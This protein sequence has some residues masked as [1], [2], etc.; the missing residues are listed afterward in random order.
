VL[1]DAA[2]A[3]R[4]AGDQQQA[5]HLVDEALALTSAADSVHGQPVR[6]A[7]LLAQRGRLLLNLRRDG[8]V[9]ALE[10]AER[11]V[12]A[13]PA[14][15]RVTVLDVLAAALVREGR[16]AEARDVCLEAVRIA[17]EIGD[18]EL[19]IS[20]RTTLANTLAQLG[21]H[22]DAVAELGA[23]RAIA[24]RHRNLP[25]LTRIAVNLAALSWA[26]GRYDDVVAAAMAGYAAARDSGRAATLGSHL[27][28][29]HA[30]ALFAVGRWAEAEARIVETLEAGPSGLFA[31]YP[32]VVGADLAAA[33]GDVALAKARLSTAHAALGLRPG[34]VDGE[35][36]TA[37]L[38]AEIALLE[39]RLAD[40][41]QAVRRVFD[42]PHG[43]INTTDAWAL[44]N[45]A[46]RVEA[47]VRVRART[48][49]DVAADDGLVESLR[50][51]AATLPAEA[52]HWRAHAAQLAAE[53]GSFETADP[54]WYAV[55]AA[56]D[57]AGEP[58]PA[59]YARLRAAEAALAAR[60]RPAAQRWLSEAQ[61]Q[62]GRLGA[63]GL[64]HQIELLA[65][66]AHLDVVEEPPAEVVPN[67]L[68]RLGLTPREAQVLRLVA[69]GR[70]NRQIATELFIAE[71][72]VSVHVSRILT[73]LGV[74]SRGVAAATAHRLRLFDDQRVG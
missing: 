63:G 27:A 35:L 4:R 29:S 49:A 52:P 58:Y 2:L 53:L 26:V 13:G 40:A 28:A 73:K 55:V 8:A 74:T 3:A 61:E 7:L 33:R 5:L 68:E 64:R 44:L 9:A 36:S 6:I 66:L 57:E 15:A 41:R 46:A 21:S 45:T 56:W 24:E 30:A 18:A 67:Q 72:T 47:H 17:G 43:R 38:T 22:D 39:H 16:L 65:R 48:M 42:T 25:G 32:N 69:D 62:A 70:S 60:E 54:A 10:E 51:V 12:E 31:A 11:L 14:A 20:T 59:A 34:A 37:R 71:K 23:V 50:K 1:E 19:E